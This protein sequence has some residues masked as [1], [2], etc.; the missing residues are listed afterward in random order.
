MPRRGRGEP[1]TAR[2]HSRSAFENALRLLREYRFEHDE[3]VRA[4]THGK[5]DTCLCDKCRRV[6][7]L[8]FE[9][10]ISL[11]KTEIRVYRHCQKQL[12]NGDWCQHRKRVRVWRHS[13]PSWFCWQ[14]R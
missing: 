11:K 4:R 8:P 12:P 6:G 9:E 7:Y 10:P 3:M 14:H 13:D 5:G 1:E 2:P